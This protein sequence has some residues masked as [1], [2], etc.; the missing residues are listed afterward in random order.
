MLQ[1]SNIFLSANQRITV[2]F[3]WNYEK[4]KKKVKIELFPEENVLSNAFKVY[5]YT[6]VDCMHT[7]T[8]NFN[9]FVLV[10]DM[11]TTLEYHQLY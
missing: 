8:P 2:N 11:D 3:Y 10:G 1:H 4:K 9:D 5:V 6:V 7:L